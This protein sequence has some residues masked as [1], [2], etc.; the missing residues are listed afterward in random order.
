[1]FTLFY[2]FGHLWLVIHMCDVLSVSIC[3]WV[4]VVSIVVGGHTLYGSC[5]FLFLEACLTARIIVS[6]ACFVD[7]TWV[8]CRHLRTCLA[9]CLLGCS[10]HQL[11][12]VDSGERSVLTELSSAFISCQ[13]WGV[14]VPNGNCW[15]CLARCSVHLLCAFWSSVLWWINIHNLKYVS[16]K[17]MWPLHEV[18]IYTSS[19][20]SVGTG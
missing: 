1:M 20:G 9:C 2:F 14:Y 19:H 15:I 3:C 13:Q 16:T 7:L 17:H 6:L 18:R 8:F 11:M 4:L 10:A 5:L 12:L